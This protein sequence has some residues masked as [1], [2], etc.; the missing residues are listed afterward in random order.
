MPPLESE[1]EEPAEGLEA[2]RS[3]DQEFVGAFPDALHC[4][5]EIP[6][7]GKDDQ[8]HARGRSL[9]MPD[10]GGSVAVGEV[11]I[12]ENETEGLSDEAGQRRAE[13]T[14]VLHVEFRGGLSEDMAH[15]LGEARIVFQE[16]EGQAL[17]VI[18]RG[19]ASLHAPIVR[20]GPDAAL[21]RS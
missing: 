11:Q 12:G 2:G 4:H 17:L 7:A 13:A 9:Q 15:E 1:A 19:G 20:A 14:G 18:R 5:V 8:R 6:V 3:L 10:G 21:S 16:K